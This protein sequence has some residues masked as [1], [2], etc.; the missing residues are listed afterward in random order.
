MKF[1]KIRI[2]FETFYLLTIVVV[3]VFSGLFI[4]KTGIEYLNRKAGFMINAFHDT[5]MN[6]Q[7]YVEIVPPNPSDL[8]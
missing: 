5:I 2:V 8:R 3:G 4:A 1:S 6:D 7:G